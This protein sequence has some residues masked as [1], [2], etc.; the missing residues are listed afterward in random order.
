[1]PELIRRGRNPNKFQEMLVLITTKVVEIE[2]K[3]KLYPESKKLY[4]NVFYCESKKL[5]KPI[6]CIYWGYITIDCGDEVILKG[7][8]IDDDKFLCWDIQIIRKK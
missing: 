2:E 6:M 1:M 7:R 8:K 3:N 5:N 4:K